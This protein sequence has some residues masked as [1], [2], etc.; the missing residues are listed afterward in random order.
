MLSTTVIAG[1]TLGLFGSLHCVGM[2]GPLALALP[3]PFTSRNRQITAS[4]FYNTGR[5]V[6]Y[7]LLGLLFG[8]I[9]KGFS[10]V[11]FQQ[12]FSIIT[13]S[14]M[15]V[16]TVLYFGFHKNYLPAWFQQFTWKIQSFIGSALQKNYGAFWVGMANALLPCGMVYAA[17]AGALVSS[18]ILSSVFFMASFGTATIPAMLTL[19]IFGSGFSAHLRIKLRKLT[20]YVMILVA[21][22]LILRGLNLGIPYVSPYAEEGVKTESIQCH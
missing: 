14:L 5:V 11:G 22:I 9:G 10:M 1:F 18:N 19:M 15:L 12:L 16:L 8:I 17:I 7:S 21:A 13:G 20:P 3:A 4:V 2:C 6:T